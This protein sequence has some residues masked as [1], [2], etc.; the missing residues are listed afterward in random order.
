[1]IVPIH[2]LQRYRCATHI[3]TLLLGLTITLLPCF[4]YGFVKPSAHMYKYWRVSSSLRSA[5]TD[6]DCSSDISSPRRLISVGFIGC[7]TIAKAIATGLATTST[8]SQ[9]T[10]NST[11]LIE[12]ISVTRRSDAK[13]K[14]LLQ[15]FPYLV[16]VFDDNQRVVDRSDI[17]FLTVLSQ[18]TSQVLQALKFD[19]KRHF[20]VSLVVSICVCVMSDCEK[21]V[22]WSE[23]ER[24]WTLFVV[25]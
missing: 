1:M 15:S 7:G 10:N 8:A 25:R 4:S 23:G 22:Q 3:Q 9:T 13:S 5:L 11:L 12:R 6:D 19:S 21:N 24:S 14:A 16:T 18:Q 17:V 20:L 2:R